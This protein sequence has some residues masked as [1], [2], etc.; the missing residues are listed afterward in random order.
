MSAIVQRDAVDMLPDNVRPDPRPVCAGVRRAIEGLR[1]VE[2]AGLFHA[3]D[4]DLPLR[5]SMPTVAT[6]HD[7]SVYD[8][9]WASSRFRSLAEQRLVARSIQRADAIIACSQFTAD[10][11]EA[12]FGRTSTVAH[13][14][15][16][17]GATSSTEHDRQRVRRQYELPDR[18]VVQVGS[19]EPRKDTT[20]LAAVC[21]ELG[22]PLVL[23]GAVAPGSAVPST[24]QHLGYVDGGDIGALLDIADIVAYVSLYEGFGLPPIEAMARGCP[25]VASAVG[26]LPEVIDSGARLVPS[27]DSEHL[28]ATLAELWSD[29]AARHDLAT[30]GRAE[31]AAL[32]WDLTAD[33]TLGVYRSLGVDL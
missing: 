29:E 28:R 26:A 6:I 5:T 18:F 11:I 22:I 1:R 33:I 19:V 8:T 31:A 20:R 2:P 27:A 4:V 15:P 24:A 30:V 32:S 14:A 16:R 25:V 23:A 9:P 10:R 17:S 7:V 13:L 3:L 12:L 21:D